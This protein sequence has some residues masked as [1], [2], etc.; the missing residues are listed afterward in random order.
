M[1][2][3]VFSQTIHL[4]AFLILKKDRKFILAHDG[5]P[6]YYAKENVQLG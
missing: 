2:L 6:N 4:R 3:Q 5:V 1:V